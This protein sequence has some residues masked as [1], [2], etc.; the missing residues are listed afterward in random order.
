M[1]RSILEPQSS[2]K[3]TSFWKDKRIQPSFTL[4]NQFL[5][6]TDLPSV[7]LHRD[8]SPA[9]GERQGSFPPRTPT[10]A[11]S[12]LSRAARP[13]TPGS[14]PMTF[15]FRAPGYPCTGV[16][17]FTPPQL[18]TEFVQDLCQPLAAGSREKRP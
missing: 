9:P 16:T 12:N 10:A 15:L 18:T 14:N 1:E 3:N 7:R 4:N 17:V 6:C 5:K 13:Q 8:S 11:S 2:I